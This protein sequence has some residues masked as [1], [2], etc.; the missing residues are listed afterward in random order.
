[1][2]R[3]AFCSVRA[4]KQDD[5]TDMFAAAVDYI[6]RA[7]RSVIGLYLLAIVI[8]VVFVVLLCSG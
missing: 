4:V 1:M 2:L 5:L 7:R 3:N 6:P 8:L